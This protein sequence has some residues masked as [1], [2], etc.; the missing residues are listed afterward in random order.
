MLIFASLLCESL[1]AASTPSA[2]RSVAPLLRPIAHAK[3]NSLSPLLRRPRRPL[4]GWVQPI[5]ATLPILRSVVTMARPKRK[6]LTTSEKTEL[7]KRWSAG[8]RVAAI[9]RALGRRPMCIWRVLKTAGG[10][11][12]AHRTRAAR[13]L[14]TVERTVISRGLSAGQSM[15]AIARSLG[16]APSTI[17]REVERHA[18]PDG[19]DAARADGQA[20]DSA[21]RPKQCLLTRNARLRWYVAT[22]LKDDWSPTQIADRL[23]VDYR[24]DH[25]MQISH[26]TIYR[27]L[28]VQA[29][30]VLKKEVLAHLRTR[31][32]LRRPRQHVE[33]ARGKILDAV[34]ISKRPAEAD[35]RAVPGHWEGDLLAGAKNSYIATLVE[36]HSRFTMLVK[37]EGKHTSTVVK[38]LAQRIRKLPLALRKSLTWDR[39]KELS[40]HRELTLATKIDV[41]FC[42]PASPWQRGSNENTNGLLRQYFPKGADLAPYTQAQLDAVARKLNGRPRKTLGSLTPAEKLSETVAMTG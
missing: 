4:L 19:Y 20:W 8:E 11:A 30:G 24:H 41:Y 28:F 26:E 40:R 42:D 16:R 38:A 37:V 33:E 21:R 22:K 39:G 34:P 2:L 9:A 35:D 10:I 6:F 15:R 12:P 18:G 5:D 17:S 14:S 7:W 32:S 31:R 25:A 27:S 1:A 23:R 3:S 36:R 29:R 13:T